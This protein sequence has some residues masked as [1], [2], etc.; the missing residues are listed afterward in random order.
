MNQR[1]G[2]AF[3]LFKAES[4]LLGIVAVRLSEVKSDITTEVDLNET[5][6]VKSVKAGNSVPVK[7]IVFADRLAEVVKNI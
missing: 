7:V 2:A 3:L 1:L 4:K 6:A 5:L